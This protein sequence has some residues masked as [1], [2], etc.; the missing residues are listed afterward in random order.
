MYRLNFFLIGFIILSI[1]FMGCT[2]PV[3]YKNLSQPAITETPSPTLTSPVMVI[4]SSNE[5][6][7]NSSAYIRIDANK[8]YEISL[9][10]IRIYP[11]ATAGTEKSNILQINMTAT[12]TGTIPV[13]LVF[14][15]AYIIDYTG[16][17]Y[18]Q[19]IHPACGTL[20]LGPMNES[21]R[22]LDFRLMPGKSIVQTENCTLFVTGH[23][24]NLLSND[25]TFGGMLKAEFPSESW[26]TKFAATVWILDLK[27]DTATFY[28]YM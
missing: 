7:G 23:Y 11:N 6:Y 22:N 3:A 5:S 8:S 20:F 1:F 4:G 27:N 21:S 26:E 14:F 18:P 28:N 12:N 2:S 13:Q 10:N 25:S 17:E 24:N 9:N 15:D 19:S 16:Y